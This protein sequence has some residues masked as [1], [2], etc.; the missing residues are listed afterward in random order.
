MDFPK[1]HKLGREVAEYQQKFEQTG[2]SL[3][4]FLFK[5]LSPTPAFPG[6]HNV[7]TFFTSQV[8]TKVS[9]GFPLAV[10]VI[11]MATICQSITLTP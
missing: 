6:I 9:G 8:K 5:M 2:Q 4:H 10:R 11:A 7:S 3:F 1:R